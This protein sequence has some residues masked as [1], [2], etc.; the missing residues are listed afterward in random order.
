MRLLKTHHVIFFQATYEPLVR[1][2]ST[3]RDVWVDWPQGPARR[4]FD[5][6]CD[7]QK[8]RFSAMRANQLQPDGNAVLDLVLD[9]AHRAGEVLA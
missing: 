2:A 9:A 5:R 7:G 1:V 4:Q 6:P 3:M 8:L